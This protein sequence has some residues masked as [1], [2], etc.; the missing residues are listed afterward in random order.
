MQPARLVSR[1]RCLFT[2]HSDLTFR[3]K[4]IKKK[5]MNENEERIEMPIL[6]I[7]LL[8]RKQKAIIL[9]KNGIMQEQFW[10]PCL[11]WQ[12]LT[13]VLQATEIIC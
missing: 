7:L 4:Q 2:L 12:N 10:E 3:K 9:L 6:S 8:K 1:E 11:K 5:K 13:P